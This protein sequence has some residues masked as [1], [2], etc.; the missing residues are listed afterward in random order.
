MRATTYKV[1]RDLVATLL[2]LGLYNSFGTLNAVEPLV[3]NSNYH[4]MSFWGQQRLLQ[5]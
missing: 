2:P 5:M 1:P 4:L 3:M